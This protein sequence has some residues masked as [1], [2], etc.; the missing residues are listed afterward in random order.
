SWE[1]QGLSAKANLSIGDGL[2]LPISHTPTL[3]HSHTPTL[4]T[5]DFDWVLGNPPF[6]TRCLGEEADLEALARN[7]TIWRESR[8]RPRMLA[9]YPI[10][11]LFLE[12]FVRLAKPG[13]YVA[14]IVPD[15]ILANA[16]LSYVREWLAAHAEIKAV[17]SLPQ[18]VFS[19]S[20]AS[21]KGS[22]LLLRRTARG[23]DGGMG[24]WEYGSVGVWEYGSAGDRSLIT[25]HSS[26]VFLAALETRGPIRTGVPGLAKLFSDFVRSPQSAIRNPKSAIECSPWLAYTAEG[27]SPG[28]RLDPAYHH[29]RYVE[30]IRFLRSLPNVVT[31]GELTEYTTYGQVGRREL[32]DSGV[33]LITPAN[34]MMTEDGYVAGINVDSPEQFVAPGSRNDPP[35]SRLRKGDLLLVNSGVGCIGR[36]AVFPSDEP[37]NISQHINLI[38]VKGVEPEYLAVYLQT[39][40]ARLQIAREKCGVGACGINFDRIKSILTPVLQEEVRHEIARRYSASCQRSGRGIAQIVTALEE[41]ISAGEKH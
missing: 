22:V 16:R 3:P 37:C 15:G 11:I 31:L 28:E 13:G 21:S 39:K 40:Y 30:N 7:Y 20:G 18:H 4:S 33:R 12:R 35:R 38:R 23:D 27:L 9:T 8:I 41:L 29:P 17:V 36:A 19:R 6:G 5:P 10:E 34:F 2:S 1:A 25:H 24:G 14:I 32:A 26:A